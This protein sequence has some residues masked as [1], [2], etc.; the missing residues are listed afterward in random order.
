[1]FVP[2]GW[3]HTVENLA[4]T[5]S[6]NHNWLNGINVHW[7]WAKLKTELE[8]LSLGAERSANGE[9]LQSNDPGGQSGSSQIGD[10]LFLLWTILST[11]AQSILYTERD[12][13]A[14]LNLNACLSVLKEMRNF[15]EQG[16]D[17]GLTERCECNIGSLISSIENYLDSPDSIIKV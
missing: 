2:S 6:I 17:Q 16:K 9:T 10:D 8:S 5:L 14:V 11:K 3:H 4:P 15:V 13:M 7:S 1:M 12:A